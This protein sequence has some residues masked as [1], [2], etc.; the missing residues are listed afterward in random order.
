MSEAATIEATIA[1][2]WREPSSKDVKRKIR[3]SLDERA[4]RIHAIAVRRGHQRRPTALI[5]R[6]DIR[7]LL[8]QLADGG[9]VAALRRV[10]QMVAH[11]VYIPLPRA[12]SQQERANDRHKP[13]KEG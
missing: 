12:P 13:Q 3:A 8:E 10:D 7:A 5:A 9:R 2:V 11:R 6:V 4:D 1:G